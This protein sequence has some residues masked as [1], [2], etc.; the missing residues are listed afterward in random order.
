MLK[1]QGKIMTYKRMQKLRNRL[2]LTV[3][4]FCGILGIKQ[5]TYYSYKAQRK[6]PET[7]SILV[8]LIADD[9]DVMVAKIRML[10]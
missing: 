3:P 10:K 8:R 7:L 2:E 1:C 6:I 5:S 9:P 4:A